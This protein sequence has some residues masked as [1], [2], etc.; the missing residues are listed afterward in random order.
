MPIPKK[1]VR[2]GE[3]YSQLKQ[4][5][6]GHE[7]TLQEAQTYVTP[8]R[9]DF[10]SAGGHTSTRNQDNSKMLYDHTAVRA[11]Q[12][13]ANGMCSY[14]MP[15]SSNW[16]YLKPESKPSAE[17]TSEELIFLEKLSHKVMHILAL[18]DCQFYSA[19]HE[20]F[21]DLGSF[22]TSV[23]Y[24][25]R[26]GPI[27]TFKSCALADT[28][29]DVNQVGKV[30]TMYHRKFLTT[31][32]LIQMFPNVVNVQGFD[33]ETT[34]AKHELVYAVEPSQ[35]IRAQRHGKVGNTRPY[36]ATYYLPAL[37]AILQEGGITYFPYLVPRWMVVAG[38]IWGRGPAYTCMPAIRVLNKM[39]KELLLSAEISN[40]PTL[41]AEEDSLLLPI[42]YGARSILYREQGS[43]VP[44][45]ILS[46][47]QPQITLELLR[48]YREQIQMSFFTDQIIRDQKKE[49]QSVVEIQDER[50]QMLQQI[51]PLLARMETEFLAPVLEH[52]IEWMQS[53]GDMFDF[54]SMPESLSDNSLEIV[55]TS[56]AA[57]AQYAS[58]VGNISGLL[59]DLA[60][61]VSMKPEIM[62]GID[63]IEL[64]DQLTKMRNVSRKIVSPKEKV[65]DTREA[66]NQQE[67]QNQ[68]MEQLPQLAG[69]M[70]DV[71]KARSD[72]PEGLGQLL[73]I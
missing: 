44:E 12:M 43:P 10:K 32:A 69:A 42:S 39:V 20:A 73:N 29:F 18:P 34:D 56:P 14:L 9:A 35:D 19:G 33:P 67:Q 48:D 11:N 59:Q 68:Q 36:Q 3:R 27:I 71:A 22:G 57:H 1:I 28:F 49:R 50:T 72:D 40:S 65:D 60:P 26:T 41:T 23:T 58:G 24:V 52:V 7:S 47:S 8:N 62:D 38:E 25:D 54:E 53:K 31:K 4:M 6:S 66:R 61:L 21:H 64:L 46:G 13:F 5:R 51:G 63:D 17:L 45:P 37:D 55:F 16:A 2:L 15:K 30:D 70:K